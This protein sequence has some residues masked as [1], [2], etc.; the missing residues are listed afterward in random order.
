MASPTQCSDQA[1]SQGTG[2]M[3]LPST[4]KRDAAEVDTL[5]AVKQ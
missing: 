1:P 4:A 5:S 2:E 3:G